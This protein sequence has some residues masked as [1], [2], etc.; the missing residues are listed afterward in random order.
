[1]LISEYKEKV[2][3]TI[4]KEDS[5]RKEVLKR[6]LQQFETNPNR[7]SLELDLNKTEEF[8]TFSEKSK[9]LI[10]SMGNMEYFVWDRTPSHKTHVCS[11]ACSQRAPHN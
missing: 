4:Q 9:A 5:H 2:H 6:L 7:D 10:T 3:S 11:T 1:M 8:N